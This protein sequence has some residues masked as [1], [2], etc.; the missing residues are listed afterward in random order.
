MADHRAGAAV[1]PRKRS[2]SEREASGPAPL[3]RSRPHNGSCPASKVRRSPSGRKDSPDRV[4]PQ[5]S[6]GETRYR[7]PGLAASIVTTLAVMI[8]ARDGFM[9]GHC[10]RMANYAT[11]IGRRRGV[12]VA[13]SPWTAGNVQRSGKHGDA[14]IA[15]GVGQR[16]KSFSACTRQVG[17]IPC[18]N[19]ASECSPM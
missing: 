3:S 17:Q 2:G 10:H 4:A 9:E 16:S 11:A 13:Y 6:H 5:R 15:I 19:S 1:F 14:G 7:R 18:E 12:R 8:E